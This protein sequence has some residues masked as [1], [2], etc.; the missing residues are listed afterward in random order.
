VKTYDVHIILGDL[1]DD[2][3][4]LFDKIQEE[5]I[6]TAKGENASFPKFDYNIVED[7]NIEAW[8][9]DETIMSQYY[10]TASTIKEVLT[11]FEFEAY[12]KTV[13]SGITNTKE[14]II[15]RI[16]KANYLLGMVKI[17]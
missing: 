4:D 5:I 8:L 9:D 11:S 3:G 16:N 17:S 13:K 6:G 12:I 2:L 1:Y 7:E 14:D 15:T 10:N